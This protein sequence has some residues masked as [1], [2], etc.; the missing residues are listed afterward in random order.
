MRCIGGT[1]YGLGNGLSVVVG[2]KCFERLTFKTVIVLLESS[3]CIVLEVIEWHQFINSD[4]QDY[5]TENKYVPMD[6]STKK[7]F[8]YDEKRII[9]IQ[10]LKTWN[11][12]KIN[13][14]QYINLKQIKSLIEC[15]VNHLMQY[16]NYITFQI[17]YLKEKFANE[18]HNLGESP[19]SVKLQDIKSEE[20]VEEAL[21]V[22]GKE[23]QASLVKSVYMLQ[24]TNGILHELEGLMTS[25]RI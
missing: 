10:C 9:V 5:F 18:C 4:L 20:M 17:Q 22:F 12:V 3:E 24:Q 16:E 11:T 23:V 14:K 15:K 13:H 7:F 19:F 25:P 6:C 21:I 8:F 1:Y 2:L